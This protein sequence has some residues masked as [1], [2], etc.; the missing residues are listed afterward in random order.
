MNLPGPGALHGLNELVIIWLVVGGWWLGF[1][2][3][4]LAGRLMEEKIS[5]FKTKKIEQ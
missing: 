2:F 3:D 1:S 5:F 4:L